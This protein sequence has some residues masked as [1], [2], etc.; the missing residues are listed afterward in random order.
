MRRVFLLFPT[1]SFIN[2]PYYGTGNKL[3]D[4]L[5]AELQRV[6]VHNRSIQTLDL[7]E[8]NFTEEGRKSISQ[9]SVRNLTLRYVIM[10]AGHSGDGPDDASRE[11][12]VRNQKWTLREDYSEKSNVFGSVVLLPSLGITI[13][14]V[15]N[16]FKKIKACRIAEVLSF[17]DNKLTTLPQQLLE[18]VQLTELDLSSNQIQVMYTLMHAYYYSTRLCIHKT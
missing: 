18:C 6:L 17:A 13:A 7:C 2:S 15:D 8:N 9:L 12:L 14:E 5:A 11:A 1:C 4:L 10:A 3:R 16:A